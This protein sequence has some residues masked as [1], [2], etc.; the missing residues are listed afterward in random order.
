MCTYIH[1]RSKKYTGFDCFFDAAVILAQK[2]AH[3]RHHEVEHHQAWR[4]NTRGQV[5]NTCLHRA[6]WI[7]AQPCKTL[8]GHLLTRSCCSFGARVDERQLLHIGSASR[9]AEKWDGKW[10]QKASR[11]IFTSIFKH[12]FLFFQ[13]TFPF[14]HLFSGFCR[15]IS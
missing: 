6:S 14:F 2:I 1:Q 3:S 13:G 5:G 7:L 8:Q 11:G 4:G 10:K 9:G 12:V 15:W